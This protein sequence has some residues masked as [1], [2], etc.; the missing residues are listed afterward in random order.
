MCVSKRL[1]LLI[2]AKNVSEKRYRG[3]LDTYFMFSTLL[4]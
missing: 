1:S 3:K 2:A 4:R